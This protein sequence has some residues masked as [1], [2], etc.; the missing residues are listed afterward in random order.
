M[1]QIRKLPREAG[2]IMVRARGKAWREIVD[3]L[4]RNEEG[5][6]A[7]NLKS[8]GPTPCPDTFCP[9]M[10]PFPLSLCHLGETIQPTS[11][12]HQDQS[13]AFDIW[14]N[15]LKIECYSIQTHPL[16]NRKT[17]WHSS[18]VFYEPG[19]HGTTQLKIALVLE[20]EINPK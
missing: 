7:Q 15:P 17:H 4:R 11:E 3:A 20:S 14:N 8:R 6:G 10:T 9:R 12:F 13:A 1:R 16:P 19:F 2:T 5:S 18:C